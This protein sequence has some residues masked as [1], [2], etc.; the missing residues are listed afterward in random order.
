MAHASERVVSTFLNVDRAERD[1]II[2]N[3]YIEDNLTLMPSW[4]W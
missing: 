2:D 4:A 1:E 3:W